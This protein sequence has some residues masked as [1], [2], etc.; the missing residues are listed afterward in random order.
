MW[1]AS[2][3]R[4]GAG[5]QVAASYP[6]NVAALVTQA[7][8]WSQHSS[9]VSTPKNVAAFVTRRECRVLAYS[10]ETVRKG[11]HG[12]VGRVDGGVRV[13]LWAQDRRSA[14]PRPARGP[15]RRPE[16]AP[17]PAQA[18]DRGGRQAA[19]ARQGRR[20]LGE[21]RKCRKRGS[22]RSVLASSSRGW[23]WASGRGQRRLRWSSFRDSTRVLRARVFSINSE[24]QGSTTGRESRRAVRAVRRTERLLDAGRPGAT[25]EA[26]RDLISCP[27][28]RPGRP[29]GRRNHQNS[30]HKSIDRES[31]KVGTQ[32][33]AAVVS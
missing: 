2:S 8:R 9:G 32:G 13:E 5:R 29:T 16:R 17:I 31:Q 26:R 1:L 27:D 14:R 33:K 11:A 25:P 23:S 12:L 21:P 22:R 28:T 20:V 30:H 6:K 3:S 19:E 24:K 18:H 15:L 7:A 4:G 10:H